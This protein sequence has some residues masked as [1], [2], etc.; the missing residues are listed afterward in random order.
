VHQAGAINNQ[1]INQVNQHE[2]GATLAESFH[3]EVCQLN[4]MRILKPTIAF[5]CMMADQGLVSHEYASLRQTESGKNGGIRRN[6][7]LQARL[8]EFERDF[9]DIARLLNSHHLGI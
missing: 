8:E 4:N 7:G 6:N 5:R 1:A 2:V 3:Q 9:I